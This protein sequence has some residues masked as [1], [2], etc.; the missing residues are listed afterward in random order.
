MEEKAK[1]I[2]KECCD[3]FGLDDVIMLNSRH[4]TKPIRNLMGVI[5]YILHKDYGFSIKYVRLALNCSTTT[6][7][8]KYSRFKFLIV[9]DKEIRELYHSLKKEE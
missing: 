1:S 5:V 4:K 2:V 6:V 3:K 7:K 9:C 8:R